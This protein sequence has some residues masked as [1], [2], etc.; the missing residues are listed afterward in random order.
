MRQLIKIILILFVFLFFNR[1]A[2]SQKKYGIDDPDARYGGLVLVQ[3]NNG[4][5]IGGY[6]EWALNS[7]N[8]LTSNLN[9]IFVRGDNDYPIYN[10]Y[11]YY[12]NT[13]YYY[14]R[15]DKT[16][17]NFLAIQLGYKRV[18]FTDK[19]ANNFRPFL[20]F[21][22]GPVVAIDPANVADWSE[23]VKNI[24]YFYSGA[25]NVG[26]GIDFATMPKSL[27]S[28]FVGYEYLN[29]PKKIDIPSE[30]PP[31]ELLDSYYTGKQDFSGLVI[32]ISIGKKF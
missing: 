29:F 3:S 15:Y 12:G 6:Y 19:L 18:L 26:A 8:H 17:L 11:S 30:L 24:D 14:E 27:I 21:N 25:V 22:A 2:F 32:K 10:P 20:Y 7:A 16:R 4:G 23:R 9:F 13:S 5:G 31:G 28:L 1:G